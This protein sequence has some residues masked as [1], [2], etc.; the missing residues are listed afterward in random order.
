MPRAPAAASSAAAIM[1]AMR[2]SSCP[3]SSG[4]QR[5]PTPIALITAA[6]PLAGCPKIRML[7]RPWIA[8]SEQRLRHPGAQTADGG[9][10]VDGP[11]PEDGRAEPTRTAE[12]S[13]AMAPA[14]RR[15]AEAGWSARGVLGAAGTPVAIL[16]VDEAVGPVAASAARPATNARRAHRQPRACGV[17]SLRLG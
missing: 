10:T 5:N 16:A 13:S 6:S 4:P 15:A 12:A 9:D 17:R 2:W 14:G 3:A 1:K 7:H 11:C 8:T